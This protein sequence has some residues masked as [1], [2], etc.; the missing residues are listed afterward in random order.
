MTE[1][2]HAK[3]GKMEKSIYRF[4][5]TMCDWT[6]TDA[7]HTKMTLGGKGQAVQQQDHCNGF[8]HGRPGLER[9]A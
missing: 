5:G 4:S 8:W 7:K 9:A 2:P 3:E 6:S 1:R